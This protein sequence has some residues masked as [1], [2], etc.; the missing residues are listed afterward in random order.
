ML[1]IAFMTVGGGF[2]FKFNIKR[3][4]FQYGKVSCYKKESNIKKICLNK[5]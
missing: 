4:E 5:V 3:F 1:S 2:D